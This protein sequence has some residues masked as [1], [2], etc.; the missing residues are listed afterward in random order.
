[1]IQSLQP[2]QHLGVNKILVGKH[3]TDGQTRQHSDTLQKHYHFGSCLSRFLFQALKGVCLDQGSMVHYIYTE[4]IA[5]FPKQNNPL[6]NSVKF[7]H[8]EK[9][10]NKKTD[11][12]FCPPQTPLA[13]VC[14]CTTPEEGTLAKVHFYQLV[15]HL[16]TVTYTPYLDL[17]RSQH[18]ILGMT[19]RSTLFPLKHT[20]SVSQGFI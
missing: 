20:F 5:P 2:K 8:S 12:Y 7:R 16:T 15:A 3:I 13:T 11:C 10:K 1:M 9:G 4:K 6:P 17:T 19:W 14:P 18:H